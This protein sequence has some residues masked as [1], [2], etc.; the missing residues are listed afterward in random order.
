MEFQGQYASIPNANLERSKLMRKSFH[1][2]NRQLTVV[3][4]V[5]PPPPLRKTSAL[6]RNGQEGPP[7]PQSQP[8]GHPAPAKYYSSDLTS[9]N[10]KSIQ[11]F[12]QANLSNISTMSSNTSMSE[13]S[14]QTVITTCAVVHNEL[15][16]PKASSAE[17][18]DDV[19]ARF[20]VDLPP[21]PSPPNSSCHSRQA[22]EDFPPPP[23]SIDLEPL[24][25]QLNQLHML[26]TSRKQ[27]NMPME[28]AGQQILHQL[29]QQKQQHLQQNRNS[30]ANWLR[31]LQAKQQ[32][33]RGGKRDG[34]TPPATGDSQVA[35]VKDLASRFEGPTKQTLKQYA[36]QELLNESP[37]NPE[38]ASLSSVSSSTSSSRM[39]PPEKLNE[40]TVDTVDCVPAAMK[41]HDMYLAKPRYDI[42]QSQIA[43]E[44]REVE[45]LN[46]LVQQTLNNGVVV[47]KRPKKKSVSFCDQVTLVATADDDEEESFIPNPILERVLRG[48]A[49]PNSADS[50]DTISVSSLEGKPNT[51]TQI[52]PPSSDSGVDVVETPMNSGINKSYYNTNSNNDVINISQR[53]NGSAVGNT[54]QMAAPDTK[55]YFSMD[56]QKAMQ[57]KQQLQSTL[58][59]QTH[60]MQRQLMLQQQ[61]NQKLSALLMLEQRQNHN[62]QARMAMMRNQ[63]NFNSG[64]EMNRKILSPPI[65]NEIAS[66]YMPVPNV[67]ASNN[68]QQQPAPNMLHQQLPPQQQQQSRIMM[69]GNLSNLRQAMQHSPVNV[70]GSQL[71]SSPHSPLISGS[72]PSAIG[73]QMTNGMVY[74]K[75]PQMMN[76]PGGSPGGFQ[77]HMGVMASPPA[78]QTYMQPPNPAM[79]MMMK[80]QQQQGQSMMMM[81]GPQY[82]VPP[83][84]QQPMVKKVSFDVGTKGGPSEHLTMKMTNTAN[85]QPPMNYNPAAAAMGKASGPAKAVLC[86][87]CRK[88]HA[89]SPAIYCPECDF[90]LSR[91]QSNPSPHPSTN[92]VNAVPMM[93]NGTVP[94]PTGVATTTLRR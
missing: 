62:N 29:Q 68:F 88:R 42:A 76:Y 18:T 63:M 74:Q 27:Q 12:H 58:H 6:T 78:S 87:L 81:G 28:D 5:A 89:I 55:N 53:Y 57:M 17:G 75:P 8:I 47:D 64:M 25:E 72:S 80:Q 40:I 50:A 91:F 46:T 14:C 43:E 93:G 26:E 84:Q 19:D 61:E 1:S 34:S 59:N 38:T 79:I 71:S 70:P 67:G 15:T 22:S 45:M 92:S 86:T 69:N 44:L 85:K 94:G 77:E 13:D 39:P 7:P 16:P 32:A 82:Q 73:A 3:S 37:Q 66:P 23:P 48:G 10:I 52:S 35:K 4:K 65:T 83:Q 36:S 41:K 31:D 54:N 60:D 49:P 20:V 9:E 21:Y 11:P 33:L 24:N 30:M 90:Y 56:P 2:S 51:P